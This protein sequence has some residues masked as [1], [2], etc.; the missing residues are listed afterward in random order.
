MNFS[1]DDEIY[2]FRFFTCCLYYRRFIFDKPVVFLVNN[3]I[4]LPYRKKLVLWNMDQ[5][6]L[7]VFVGACKD[8]FEEFVVVLVNEVT[9]LFLQTWF[10]FFEFFGVLNHHGVIF[11]TLWEKL[12][13][14]CENVGWKE[15]FSLVD[16]AYGHQPVIYALVLY[17]FWVFLSKIEHYLL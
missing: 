11:E 15:L 9:Y 6:S 4:G 1:A 10:Q 17:W 16:S 12:S 13:D 7:E 2:V 3:F 8:W 14:A 5:W